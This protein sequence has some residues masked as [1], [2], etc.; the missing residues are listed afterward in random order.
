MGLFFGYLLMKNYVFSLK[1]NLIF[2]QITR[3]LLIN[4]L[5]FLQTF[6]ITIALKY[7]LDFFLESIDLI[8]LIAHIIG[9]SFPAFTSYFAHK[10]YTFK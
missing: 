1:K 6:L 7:F 10:Y 3:F 5:A 2:K 9:V 8:E 4:T